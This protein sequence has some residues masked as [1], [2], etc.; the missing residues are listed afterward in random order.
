MLALQEAVNIWYR[1]SRM[2]SFTLIQ[3]DLTHANS[4]RASHH[5]PWFFLFSVI[6]TFVIPMSVHWT[7]VKHQNHFNGLKN[8]KA[9][10]S[11]QHRWNMQN[12][13]AFCCTSPFFLVS[14]QLPCHSGSVICRPWP[15]SPHYQFWVT[16]AAAAKT[17][18]LHIGSATTPRVYGPAFTSFMVR[19][20]H[21][22]GN[23]RGRCSPEPHQKRF[24]WSLLKMS[25]GLGWRC[26]FL[27]S[28]PAL[29]CQS[30]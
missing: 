18:S 24:I 5:S 12:L 23:V 22:T 1:I 6:N 9:E 21:E 27:C 8:I 10:K 11:Q 26:M 30:F 25:G 20:T 15:S 17:T 29:S 7:P 4:P 2:W 14:P 19:S 28:Y 16:N 3:Q 13:T